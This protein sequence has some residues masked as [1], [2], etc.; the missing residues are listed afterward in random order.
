[1]T[2]ILAI[3]LQYPPHHTGG[4]EVSCHDVVVRLSERGHQVE[5]LTSDLRRPGVEDPEDDHTGPVLV[6][7][8]LK[9]W[10]RDDDLYA[11]GRLERLRWERANQKALERVLDRFRPQVVSAWQVGGL[12]LG[13][14]TTIASRGIPIVHAISDD[15]LS[16]APELDAWSRMFRRLPAG[17]A[18]ASGGLLGVSTTV[19]DLG[20]TGP[21]LFISEV[22][23]RRAA[24]YAPWSMDDTSIIYSGIDC[25]LFRPPATP[26]DERWGGRLL[27]VGRYDP[28]KGI[29]TAIRALTH[30]ESETLEV[31]GTGDASEL[32][33]L[34][35][36]AE[37]LG[38]RERVSFEAVPRAELVG[39]YAAAD[40]LI[41][42]SEWEEPFGLVPV[43][44]MACGTPV[45]ATGVGGSGEFLLDPG[46]C[47]RF[48]PGDPADL[49]RAVRRLADD[50]R[51][52]RS[53]V[54][55]GFETA[56]Y[57]D[58][59]R[60]TDCLEAWLT[61]AATGY[62]D[63]RPDERRFRLDGIDGSA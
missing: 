13:L 61:G 42:P 51:L 18:R 6:H 28:R 55:R 7:R 32:A 46:N 26:R 35:A 4:Y 17:V 12:S 10:F 54:D 11:P 30:L 29:E 2:R 31:Q 14:L 43:E 1:L 8:D 52:R 25:R 36:I 62:R 16:Y 39:R 48:R 19:P 60:L 15:W 34:L 56:R 37:E 5:V 3:G 63:G 22:T 9:A 23:R 40:A 58:V 45:V 47:V 38:V 44:A 41:F 53:L 59:D 50:G 27:Y 33:R 24:Q 20:R 57:F 49:A 21:F